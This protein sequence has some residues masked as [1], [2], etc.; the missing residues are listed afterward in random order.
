M[1]LSNFQRKKAGWVDVSGEVEATIRDSE[2]K[3]CASMPCLVTPKSPVIRQESHK[4][5]SIES[6]VVLSA[7]L[8]TCIAVM[9]KCI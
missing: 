9:P 2:K 5:G 4:V 3:K 8:E 6:I 7:V 1:A